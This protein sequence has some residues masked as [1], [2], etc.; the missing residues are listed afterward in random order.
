MTEEIRSYTHRADSNTLRDEE[1]MSNGDNVDEEKRFVEFRRKVRSDRS[2][3]RSPAAAAAVAAVY[4]TRVRGCAKRTHSAFCGKR[5]RKKAF[6]PERR[7]CRG[8]RGVEHDKEGQA[9][10]KGKG[11]R[12]NEARKSWRTR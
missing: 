12:P 10:S 6:L 3:L 7:G 9:K 5:Y 2:A 11:A 8:V 4:R 1:E